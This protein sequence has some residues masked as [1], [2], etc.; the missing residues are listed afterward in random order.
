MKKWITMHEGCVKKSARTFLQA[1]V[2][3]FLTSVA[4]GEFAINEWR[5]WIF[6]LCGS[7]VSAGV[8][9][10]MNSNK[11]KEESA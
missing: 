9:A 8:S 4:S 10:V 7:A 11:K 5:T 3:V 2:G 6:T 1:A